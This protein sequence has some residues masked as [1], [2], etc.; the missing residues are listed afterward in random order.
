MEAL[1]LCD[2]PRGLRELCLRAWVCALRTC[3]RRNGQ[4]S[5]GQ[6]VAA[7]SEK[8]CRILSFGNAWKDTRAP[9]YSSE[10][11]VPG[12]CSCGKLKHN[13]EQIQERKHQM[14]P[15][16]RHSIATTRQTI[17]ASPAGCRLNYRHAKSTAPPNLHTQ[18]TQTAKT[19]K[20]IASPFRRAHFMEIRIFCLAC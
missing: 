11:L 17:P 10:T 6:F 18:R 19:K 9:D 7:F 13:Y 4:Q 5:T 14:R 20:T 16:R 1:R 2:L 3:L 15:C 8:V 12:N